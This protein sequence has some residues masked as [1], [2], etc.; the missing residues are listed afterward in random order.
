MLDPLRLIHV[1]SELI[2]DEP[3][4]LQLKVIWLSENTIDTVLK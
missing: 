3:E 2:Q 1:I 4:Q